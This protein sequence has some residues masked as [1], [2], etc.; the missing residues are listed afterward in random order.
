MAETNAA[1]KTAAPAP[2]ADD[3]KP[4]S[5]E[6]YQD[7]VT[8]LTDRFNVTR[9]ADLEEAEKLFRDLAKKNGVTLADTVRLVKVN[10]RVGYAA[11]Y[12]FEGT[13]K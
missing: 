1:A 12:T 5:G 2:A 6:F 4:K 7:S 3:G 8:R 11:E 9:P 13:V 10:H